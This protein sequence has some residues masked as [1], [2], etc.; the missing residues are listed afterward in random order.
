MSGDVEAK[1]MKPSNT[2]YWV[3][4]FA[5]VLAV[6]QYIDRVCISKSKGAIQ[7]DLQLDDIAMG[8]VLGAFA[9]AYA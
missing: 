5:V 9:L 4:V 7:A 3:V 8:K 1:N 6:I 2:R